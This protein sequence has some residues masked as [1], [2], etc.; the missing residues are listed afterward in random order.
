MDLNR[1]LAYVCFGIASLVCVRTVAGMDRS[2][3]SR[4]NNYVVSRDFSDELRYDREFSSV[5]EI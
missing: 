3:L 2:Y 5:L 1:R 4:E